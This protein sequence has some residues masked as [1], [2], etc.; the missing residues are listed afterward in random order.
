MYLN[1]NEINTALTKIGGTVIND[2]IY[3]WSSTEY[4]IEDAWEIFFWI[5]SGD[6]SHEGKESANNGGYRFIR[7]IN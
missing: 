1:M 6:I 7:D 4:D 3:Y 5:G 2:A